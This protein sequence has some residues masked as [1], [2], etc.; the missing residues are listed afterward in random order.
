MKPTPVDPNFD[1]SQT[2]AIETWSGE[3]VWHTGTIL[4][5][6]PKH[7]NNSPTDTVIPIEVFYDPKTGRILDNFLPES[8]RSVLN[9]NFMSNADPN[10]PSNWGEPQQPQQQQMNWG[11]PQQQP[12]LQWEN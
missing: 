3:Q 1:F 7:I 5:K 8:L 2:E 12:P 11:E 10:P 4:R 6:V 9:N